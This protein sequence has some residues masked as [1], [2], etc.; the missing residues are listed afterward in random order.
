[1]QSSHHVRP[2]T[3]RQVLQGLF[4]LALLSAVLAAAPCR[5]QAVIPTTARTVSLSDA[6]IPAPV[7]QA[8]TKARLHGIAN[9][10]RRGPNFTADGLTETGRPARIVISGTTGAIL[11]LRIVEPSALDP[12]GRSE[13]R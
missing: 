10:R 9:L 11:G 3:L 12:A 13:G 4:A 5:A 2:G 8:F 1:V 7:L 6:T